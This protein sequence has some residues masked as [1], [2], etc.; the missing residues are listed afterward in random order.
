ML[1]K[2]VAGTVILALVAASQSALLRAEETVARPVVVRA[3]LPLPFGAERGYA[4][5][6]STWGETRWRVA[7]AWSG[8]RGHER[9]SVFVASERAAS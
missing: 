5:F 2:L 7:A 4:S 9:L 3:S 6:S 1:A 8:G